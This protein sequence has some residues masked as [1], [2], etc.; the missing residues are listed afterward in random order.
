M[1]EVRRFWFRERFGRVISFRSFKGRVGGV[2]LVKKICRGYRSS[3]RG[4]RFVSYLKGDFCEER[5]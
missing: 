5:I 2:W 1:Y 4:F 3:V